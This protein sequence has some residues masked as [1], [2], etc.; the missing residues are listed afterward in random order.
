MKLDQTIKTKAFGRPYTPSH[1]RFNNS[2]QLVLTSAAEVVPRVLSIIPARSVIDV[3]CGTGTWL[4]VFATHG[5]EKIVGVDGEYTDR[6]RLDIDAHCF[7]PWDLNTP[8]GRLELGRFDL[9]ISL[10]VAEHLS[11]ARAD[12]FVADLCNLSDVILF[13][14]AV[15][16]QTGEGHINEQWQSYWVK[17][18]SD[19]G[20][21]PYDALR[22]AIWGLEGIPF[23]YKQNTLY[24]VKRSS[25]A[26]AVF[27]K[28]LHAPS[29]AMFDVVHPKLFW[30]EVS[31]P[32]GLARLKKA[33]Y[34]IATKI[35]GSHS[36]KLGRR[37][38]NMPEIV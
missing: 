34:R 10:E 37:A 30:R 17:K 13:G 11:P 15:I 14:A 36:L 7:I 21:D 5:V 3:G 12:G 18:F 29:T 24:Y 25:A 6:R 9:A 28:H 8:L 33:I 26:E 19:R 2:R 20:Y 27:R 1:R 23:W 4:N 38:R 31:A 16:G 22:P 35:T 32:R